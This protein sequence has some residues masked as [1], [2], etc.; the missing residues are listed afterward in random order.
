M[1]CLSGPR[2]AAVF[3]LPTRHPYA[4]RQKVYVLQKLLYDS[5]TMRT[6]EVDESLDD[7]DTELQH[8]EVFTKAYTITADLAAP[9]MAL[10]A[11]VRARQAEEAV[12]M[13]NILAGR[14]MALSADD[15]LNHIVD[16]TKNAVLASSNND[17]QAPLYKQLFAGQSPSE[18][19]RPLLGTQLATMRN[20]VGPLGAAG[21]PE[22]SSIANQLT[23]AIGKADDAETKMALAHQAMDVFKAGPRKA[24]I[25]ACNALRSL[26]QG[27][28][29]ELA[30]AH[31][32]L[33]RDFA[34]RFFM[35]HG[36]SRSPS[37]FE[38]E[39]AVERAHAKLNR[40]QAQLETAK[41]KAAQQIRERQE[42]ELA[43]RKARLDA[44]QKRAAEAAAE[45]AKLE[46]ELQAG[47]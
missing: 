47:G 39:Q 46:A 26:T 22:L 35:T 5:P 19:K 1:R 31:P 27:K 38:L 18:L 23:L 42:A 45:V 17:Y 34:D 4:L 44:A 15:A 14:A 12:L 29:G 36:G 43:E 37:I 28:I 8:T 30:H 41:E 10:R 40:L 20:W 7:V 6:L 13:D 16:A 11:E 32:E 21:N 9:F 33:P 25:E 3:V 2:V 24:C